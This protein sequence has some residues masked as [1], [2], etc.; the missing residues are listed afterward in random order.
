MKKNQSKLERF[1]VLEHCLS[2]ISRISSFTSTKLSRFIFL[3]S[4]DI[5]VIKCIQGCCGAV[6]IAVIIVV[7]AV[8]IADVASTDFDFIWVVEILTCTFGSLRAIQI[9]RD[10]FCTFLTTPTPTPV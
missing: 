4:I 5:H 8:V 6:V 9:I 7:E 10:T 1:D 3:L 2:V